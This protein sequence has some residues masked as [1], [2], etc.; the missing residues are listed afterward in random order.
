MEFDAASFDPAAKAFVAAALSYAE[1]CDLKAEEPTGWFDFIN[2]DICSSRPQDFEPVFA[3]KEAFDRATES[4]LHVPLLARDLGDQ[5]RIFANWI[6]GVSKIQV[7]RG[8][9]RVYQGLALAL[10]AYA[11]EAKMPTEPKHALD[12]YFVAYPVRGVAY[13]WEQVNCYDPV[14]FRWSDCSPTSPYVRMDRYAIHRKRGTPLV[15]RSSPQGPYLA[16]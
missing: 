3:A 11:P 1:T 12:Q 10:N 7:S 13:I 2:Y 5:I 8:T 4:M 14:S 6:D 9:M 15:W 16:E